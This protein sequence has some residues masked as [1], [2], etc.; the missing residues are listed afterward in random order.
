MVKVLVVDDS[1][2]EQLMLSHMLT[3]ESGIEVIG[4]ADDGISAMNF[5]KH[6]KPD[7]ITMDLN[8]PGVDGLQVTRTIM[9]SQP[10]PI[11]IVTVDRSLSTA[12]NAF[13]LIEA[14][15]VGIVEKP[16][17]INDAQHEEIARQL[18]QLV[19]T[20]AQVKLVHRWPKKTVESMPT[21][22]QVATAKTLARKEA[23]TTR[24]NRE[25]VQ[26]RKLALP[27]RT[28]PS[29]KAPSCIA[30]GA[31]TGG[32]SVIK[33]LLENLPKELNVPIFI[34]QHIAPGFSEGF[35]HWLKRH[36]THELCLGTHRQTIKPGCIYLAPS[37]Y[38][39]GVDSHKRIILSRKNSK[40]ISSVSFLF[41]SLAGTFGNS[42]MAILLTGMGS[43]GAKEMKELRDLGAIT[44][45]QDQKSSV[46]HG[47]PD[48]AIKLGAAEHVM[49]PE[50][51]SEFIRKIGA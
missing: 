40:G 15:A 26:R 16:C 12:A 45:A 44:I 23:L 8:M 48:A 20:M 18:R 2:T 29:P 32:P 6:T 27:V 24:S 13:K 50:E 46:I 33:Y 22:G 34:V 1:R 51:I 11:I 19:R 43:D 38:D 35:A 30:I 7:V 14:G 42:A 47:M 28:E 17:I 21:P 31:S 36:V 10:I 9:E 41:K 5:L 4:T 3:S 39:M 25:H 37:P 49:N